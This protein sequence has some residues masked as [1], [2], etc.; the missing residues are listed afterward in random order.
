MSIASDG[1]PAPAPTP[2]PDPPDPPARTPPPPGC[3]ALLG[4]PNIG[5]T[6]L[7][8]R[9]CGMRAKT[10]NFGGSTVEARVGRTTTGRRVDVVDL[11]GLYGLNLDRP[12]SRICRAFL[13]GEVTGPP[14]AEGVLVVADAAHLRRTL[15]FTNQALQQGL[16]SVVALNMV[17]VAERHG[18]RV[19]VD[20]LE[21]ALGCPVVPICARTGEGLEA[22]SAALD[23]P[24]QA[25]GPLADPTD[26]RAAAA[27]AAD[28][29]DRV[30]HHDPDAPPYASA[31]DRLDA[32]LT[33]PLLGLIVFA[34]VMSGL[35][36][37]IFALATLPM[38]LI[39]LSFAWVGGVLETALPAGA[40]RD[41]VVNGIVGGV[42]GTVVF[43]PQI[44]LLFFLIAI[45]EESGYLARAVFVTERLMRVFGLPGQSFVPL[46]SAHACAIPAIMS[47]RL[48]TDRRDRIATILVAPFMSCSARLPVY[49]LLVGILFGDRP[50]LAGLAFTGCYALGALAALLTARLARRTVLP[51]R[52][53]PMILEL[54][55]YRRPSLRHALLLTVDRAWIFLRNAGTVIV[56]ICVVLWW[57]SAYPKVEP[58]ASAAALRTEAIVVATV[59]AE[60]SAALAGEADLLEARHAIAGS[61]AG[62]I[63][64]TIEPVFAPLGLDWQLTIG[65]VTS[66]AAREVF[67]STLAII[68]A[69]TDD[70]EDQ[71]VLDR[72]RGARRDDGQPLWTPATAASLLVFYVLAMQCLPTLPVTARES[73]HWGWAV[74]QFTYMT[75]LAWTFGFVVHVGLGLL[76]VS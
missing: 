23:R 58:P 71:A 25:A 61:F 38:D 22:L 42:A 76:G 53:A 62:R 13:H 31:T 27:W 75:A 41:L 52:A 11:P 69:G 64:R 29:A 17:D 8:N 73:G 63:G 12:E 45:L 74:L 35:F 32:V 14:P 46:L 15:I 4:H 26:A 30:V 70:A 7:F 47:T 19:D 59:D 54:P 60:A 37:A 28:L 40:L 44:C 43:L 1:T 56:A 57:L 5:K 3:F 21:A 36:Y 10:A 39:E 9:L 65:V 20:A 51:G 24:R 72:I 33:H 18:D 68:F 34:M 50:L 49:V 66:F 55:S 16:P 6:T 67:V 2:P 48:I